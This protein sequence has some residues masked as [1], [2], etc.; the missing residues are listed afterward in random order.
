MRTFVEASIPLL[1]LV[2]GVARLHTW[3]DPA[4]RPATRW[5]LLLG[6]A[7]LLRVHAW[8]DDGIGPVLHELTGWWNVPM[9]VSTLV[10]TVALVDIIATFLGATRGRA[11]PQSFRP[12]ITATVA[13]VVVASF[14]TSPAHDT[15]VPDYLVAYGAA[16]TL[17]IHW[18]FLLGLG[19]WAAGLV[20]YWPL[21]MRKLAAAGPFRRALTTAALAGF[22]GVLY[23]TYV[24][25][26]VAMDGLG[27]ATEWFIP[28]LALFLVLSP[29][30][31]HTVVTLFMRV[32]MTRD[33]IRRFRQIRRLAQRWETDVRA[34]QHG[35]VL[36]GEFVAAAA[37]SFWSA[38]A[39]SRDSLA[40]HRLMV[41]I[42]D[43]SISPR[44]SDFSRGLEESSV[45]YSA[46]ERTLPVAVGR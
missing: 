44:K 34:R 7:A 21:S 32:Q 46:N 36:A 10:W 43:R 23:C 22:L 5:A 13:A 24:G 27:L 31:L 18:G 9:L 8:F 38:W 4:T 26:Y 20:M 1:L 45:S 12:A 37:A 3:N 16:G 11:V 14:A 41:E 33:R 35:T 42:A 25:T 19:L 39:A 2:Y 30:L 6:T 29:L 17:W 15:P 40:A 28:R